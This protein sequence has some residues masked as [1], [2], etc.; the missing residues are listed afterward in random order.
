MVAIKQFLQ[1]TAPMSTT[2]RR[3][4]ARVD[5][6]SP[7]TSPKSL[8]NKFP[9][10]KYS[11]SPESPNSSPEFL[12]KYHED[13]D[14]VSPIT[15]PETIPQIR[16]RSSNLF[17][18]IPKIKRDSHNENA[19]EKSDES[20]TEKS[21]NDSTEST[22]NEHEKNT[23]TKEKTEKEKNGNEI[24]K[25]NNTEN[26]RETTENETDKTTETTEIIENDNESENKEKERK[27]GKTI[28]R[29]SPRS[30]VTIREKGTPVVLRNLVKKSHTQ[31]RPSK[32]D[33]T[34]NVESRVDLR[35]RRN[36]AHHRL[37]NSRNL[38][39]MKKL[40]L[41]KKSGDQF[42]LDEDEEESSNF[43]RSAPNQKII[44]SSFDR[45]KKS[46][47]FNQTEAKISESMS[48]GVD[49]NTIKIKIHFPSHYPIKSKIF[50]V[51][52]DMTFKDMIQDVKKRINFQDPKFKV[53][54][55]RVPNDISF[56][57]DHPNLQTMK[58]MDCWPFFPSNSLVS[59]FE[60]FLKDLDYVEFSPPLSLDEGKKI[61]KIHFSF[62]IFLYSIFLF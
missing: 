25:E 49:P 22:E 16:R 38:E 57:M 41:R 44:L 56:D 6:D 36:S 50:R 21:E 46:T 58:E 37:Q 23:D 19:K 33:N 3:T 35:T 34:D 39:T 8:P 13:V 45:Y 20:S 40:S 1:F 59:D 4:T 52:L 47:L 11:D 30:K 12:R 51:G 17:I 5:Y 53:I 55:V 24:R 2:S 43:S 27:N 9:T 18:P 7:N 48:I 60:P 26:E 14:S 10:F 62:F 61:K 28:I 32:E 54:M 15:T 42:N 29:I 31:I